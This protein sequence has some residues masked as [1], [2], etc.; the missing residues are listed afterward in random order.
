MAF[1]ICRAGAARAH[2]VESLLEDARHQGRLAHRHRPF[3]H[4]LGDRL[5][6]DGLEILLVEPG[7]RRL[8]G[9]AEDRDGIGAGRIE[10]GDHVGAGRAGGADADA[11]IAGPGPGVTLGHMRGALD[12]A[13]QDVMDRATALQGGIERV[14][15]RARHAEGLGHALALQN[16]DRSLDSSHSRH[17]RSPARKPLLAYQMPDT[18]I[19]QFIS[20]YFFISHRNIVIHFKS[21]S[22]L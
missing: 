6:V 2:D 22:Y 15:R 10:P 14:D 11:D 12:M 19:R 3:G 21:I 7:A 18:T 13:R 4:R 1:S 5:D 20:E 8:A 9:D 17:A 16:P